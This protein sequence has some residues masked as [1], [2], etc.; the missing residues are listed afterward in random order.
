MRGKS[1]KLETFCHVTRIVMGIK[2]LISDSMKW[3]ANTT[4]Y[5]A[6]LTTLIIV[7]ALAHTKH[8]GKMRLDD[9]VCEPLP[10]LTLPK[11]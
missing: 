1:N 9:D 11:R 3:E 8:H 2:D 10:I 6:K 7:A 4:L 5:C